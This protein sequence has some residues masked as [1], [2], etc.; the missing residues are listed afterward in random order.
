V[1][2]VTIGLNEYVE[3]RRNPNSRSELKL[4]YFKEHGPCGLRAPGGF[5]VVFVHEVAA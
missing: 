5:F 4:R 3:W 1:K 2:F